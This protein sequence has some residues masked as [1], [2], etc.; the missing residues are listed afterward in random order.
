MKKK[1]GQ[2]GSISN[3]RARFDYDLKDSF[4]AGLVLNGPEVRSIRSSHLSLTGSFITMKDGEAWLMNAHVT[5]LK[6][7]AAHLPSDVQIR[8]RKLLLKK[9]ELNSLQEAKNQGLTIVPLRV[10]NKSK[11]IKIE[12]AV[13]KGKR[14]YDKRHSIKKRDEERDARRGTIR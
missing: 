13:G 5:P 14:E 6:T 1:A 11:F 9:R 7:N 12:I 8:N 3:K 4:M 2:S 10:L